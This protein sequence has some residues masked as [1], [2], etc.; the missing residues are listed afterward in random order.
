MAYVTLKDGRT[1]AVWDRCRS[2]DRTGFYLSIYVHIIIC[3]WFN[4]CIIIIASRLL[5]AH[6][7]ISKLLPPIDRQDEQR[8]GFSALL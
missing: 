6:S 2:D 3:S 5:F 1:Y 4:A 7:D 8:R